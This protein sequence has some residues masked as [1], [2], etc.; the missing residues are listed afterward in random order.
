M[1]RSQICQKA[2]RLRQKGPKLM[3]NL[4]KFRCKSRNF[5]KIWSKNDQ[6]VLKLKRKDMKL[7]KTPRKWGEKTQH[8][9][10][11]KTTKLGLG[12][13]SAFLG[14]HALDRLLK[15]VLFKFFGHILSK[16]VKYSL[17]FPF[18]ARSNLDLS[19]VPFYFR[20]RHT[21]S[22]IFKYSN[23]STF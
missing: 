16:R 23:N 9:P 2:T 15:S 1:K 8:W 21:W 5:V 4:T 7:T 18:L 11:S 14:R 22:K 10:N 6:K 12:R 3:W 13:F 17:F 19:F 20:K